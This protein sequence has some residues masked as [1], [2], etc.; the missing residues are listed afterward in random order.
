MRSVVWRLQFFALLLVA[1]NLTA[2]SLRRVVNLPLVLEV[3]S[4]RRC[5]LSWRLMIAGTVY[6]D[7]SGFRGKNVRVLAFLTVSLGSQMMRT[8]HI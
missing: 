7:R 8:F 5:R 4:G 1:L 2:F 6:N 3:G